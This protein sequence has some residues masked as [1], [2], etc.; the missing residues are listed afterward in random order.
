VVVVDLTEGGARVVVAA[1]RGAA[2]AEWV[3]GRVMVETDGF[4][5]GMGP[6]EEEEVVEALVAVEGRAEVVVLAVG[7]AALVGPEEEEKQEIVQIRGWV[8]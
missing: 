6:V 2:E 3:V 4:R 1:A 5:R 8:I 7:G